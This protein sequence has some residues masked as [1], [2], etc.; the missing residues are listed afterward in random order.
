MIMV[1][2]QTSSWNQRMYLGN[3]TL[4]TSVDKLYFDATANIEDEWFINV[5]LDLANF[6]MFDSDSVLIDTSTDV[7]SD[8]W[9]AIDALI[10][11]HVPI[12]S[13]LMVC[14]KIS[15]ARKAFFEVPAKRKDQKLILFGR[16]ESELITF[17]SSGDESD[18]PNSFIMDKSHIT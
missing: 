2:N 12:K 9:S 10:L 13:S 6:F 15:D 17:E 16:I 8:S 14:E 7:D 5:N 11:L 1:M 4:V 3:K 18:P